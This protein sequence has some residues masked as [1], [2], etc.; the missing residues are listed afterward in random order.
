M[1][2][3][4]IAD[5]ELNIRLLIKKVV[6]SLGYCVVGEASDGVEAINLYEKEKPD[7]L[8][9]DIYMPLMEGE[10][11]LEDILSHFPEACI[12][13][14][15]SV[16]DSETVANCIKLGAVNYILKSTP[17]K[18]IKIRIKESYERCRNI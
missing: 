11:A 4:I 9:L 13:M 10:A 16:A 15:T 7:L 5:D 3:V 14:M 17:I 18:E 12:I 2:R 8:L 1:V 6:L